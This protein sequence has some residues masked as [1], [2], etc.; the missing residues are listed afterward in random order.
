LTAHLR[1]TAAIAPDVLLP[2][3]PGLA[4]ALAQALLD[5]PVMA[6]HSHGLWGYSGRTD[7]GRGRTIQATGI[8]GPSAAVVV[9]E[10][11]AHGASRAVRIGT[12][13][14]LDAGL[15]IG[16]VVV[17]GAILAADGASRA[18]S[19][20]APE[21]DPAL[22]AALASVA[23]TRPATVASSDLFHD[24]HRARRRTRW[25]DAG[26]AVADLESA[27]VLAVG[28]RLGLACAATLVVAETAGGDRDEEA[29]ERGLL[30]LG[31]A[32]ARA[33]STPLAAQ[34]VGWE[35]SRSP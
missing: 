15:G 31:E 7:A 13:S 9:A 5:K 3:D 19:D 11:G 18:L 32:A 2:G 25:V 35:A 4:L 12:C 27:A 33:L 10:L 1:P 28:A 16:D 34:P 23:G 14:A 30:A 21:P 26:A 29:T 17:A 8:G 20:R 22:T 6:N 24:P